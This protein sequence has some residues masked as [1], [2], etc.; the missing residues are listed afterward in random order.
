[1][2]K[3]VF[4][5][6]IFILMNE[7]EILTGVNLIRKGEEIMK[8]L[9]LSALVIAAALVGATSLKAADKGSAAGG[10]ELSG[11][12]DV[13]TGWQHDSKN[14]GALTNFVNDAQTAGLMGEG[15]LGDLRGIGAAF[16]DTFDFYIDQVELDINKTFGENIRI[17]ADLD[18]GRN[19]SGSI[20]TTG[21]QNF[22]LEQG[23]VTANIPIG[24]GLEFL[25]GRF[26][27]PL[28]S[29]S[30]DRGNNVALSYSNLY[31]YVRPYNVTGA[32]LYYAFND[33]FDWHFYAVNN[34]FDTIGYV[35]GVSTDTPIPSWGTRFGF[36]WGEKGKESVVGLSYAGGPEGVART[37]AAGVAAPVN[38]MRHFTNIA[39]LDFSIHATDNFIIAGEGIFRQDN[40][41]GA[42]FVGSAKNCRAYGGN[43]VLAYNFSETWGMYLRYDYLKDD[44]G[45]YT[46]FKQQ[47]HDFALGASYQITEGAKMKM[48]YRLDM[49]L[50]PA[51]VIAATSQK[52]YN[53][54]FALE[55]AYNF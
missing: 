8:K 36:T 25:V 50:Y 7:F 38:R 41:G 5:C 16:K 23:Y 1:M 28:G 4:L 15:Q 49:Q 53:N 24:N 32:K 11:N 12:V 54:S 18:F 29:E 51:G 2:N 45:N 37:T 30:V 48:E 44:N 43:L 21:G 40:K 22:S 39:D 26:N 55:F 34:L 3:E 27:I 6:L 9:G 10:L 19:L 35:A 17:R 14:A 13:V 20:R 33:W 42:C 46:G 47:I 52:G 31:R